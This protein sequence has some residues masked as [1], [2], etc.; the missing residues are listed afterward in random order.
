V[1]VPCLDLL[2]RQRV[3]R[4]VRVEVELSAFVLGEELASSVPKKFVVSYLQLERF[5]VPLVVQ[6]EVVRV[7]ESDRLVFRLRSQDVSKR[8]ILEAELLANFVVVRNVDASGN[9]SSR[10]GYY[11][12][13]SEVR[14]VEDVHFK[15]FAPG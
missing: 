15:C 11:L 9:V 5:A 6:V 8:D 4:R 7:D 1:L 14:P 2:S 3:D 12:E 10:K 13:R